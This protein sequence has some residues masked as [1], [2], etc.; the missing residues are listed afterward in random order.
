[1]SQITNKNYKQLFTSLDGDLDAYFDE[2]S[3]SDVSEYDLEKPVSTKVEA[4]TSARHMIFVPVVAPEDEKK[5]AEFGGSRD[6]GSECST[7]FSFPC[8]VAIELMDATDTPLGSMEAASDSPVKVENKDSRSDF[9]P[10]LS[11]GSKRQGTNTSFGSSST[12]HKSSSSKSAPF[13]PA[14]KFETLLKNQTK[15]VKFVNSG[16]GTAEIK[17]GWMPKMDQMDYACDGK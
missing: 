15:S 12:A 7:Y 13:W 5:C 8:P 14:S 11:R 3:D 9:G 1:M 2:S 6:S 4:G 17:R 10:A 16:W